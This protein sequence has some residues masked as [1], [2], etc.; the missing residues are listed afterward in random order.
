[1]A[2]TLSPRLEQEIERLCERYPTRAAALLPTLQAAQRELGA[3]D[4]AAIGMVAG[5]LGVPAVRV[6][7]VATWYTMFKLRPEGRHLVEICTNLSCHLCGGSEL[8]DAVC[9]ELG[10]RPGETTADGR[11]TVREVECLGSCGTA[12]VMQIDGAFV[13]NLTLEKATAALQSAP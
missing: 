3:L 12:P 8:L 1:M 7:E 9:R 6:Q 10:V 5:A 11:F 13:E 4:E 2:P